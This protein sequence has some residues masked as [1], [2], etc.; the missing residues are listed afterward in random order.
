MRPVIEASRGVGAQRVTVNA[1]RCGFHFQSRKL[2]I[3]YFN[4]IYVFS[5]FFAL[6]STQSVALSSAT[7]FSM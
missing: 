7:A 6:V 3:S 2:N 4:S 5:Y 1:I